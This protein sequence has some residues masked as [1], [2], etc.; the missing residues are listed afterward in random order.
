MRLVGFQAGLVFLVSLIV[1]IGWGEMAGISALCGGVIATLPNGVYALYAFRFSGARQTQQ[2]YASLKRGVA[3]KYL[4]T[5]VL[6][7][8][9]FKTTFVVLFPLFIVY[10]LAMAANWFASMFFN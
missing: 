8:L 3:L 1:F 10:T 2:V 5:I 4:L 9:V 6:F 7:A